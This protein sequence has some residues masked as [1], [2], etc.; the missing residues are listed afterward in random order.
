MED[1]LLDK[2]EEEPEGFD[3]KY[4]VAASFEDQGNHTTVTALFNNQAYHSPAVALA[5]VDNC[6]FKLLSGAAASI[7]ASNHPQPKSA[8]EASEDVLYK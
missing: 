4:V 6:L 7:T 3:F 2:A 8:L 1:L 5:L